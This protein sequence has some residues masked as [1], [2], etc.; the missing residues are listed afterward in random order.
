MTADNDVAIELD[1]EYEAELLRRIQEMDSG[2]A[3]MLPLDAVLAR[4]RRQDS[5][6]SAQANAGFSPR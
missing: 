4:F 6:L 2:Q 5:A 1:P 3:K